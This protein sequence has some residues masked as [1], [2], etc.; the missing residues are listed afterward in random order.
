MDKYPPV[1]GEIVADETYFSGVFKENR[2]RG[3]AGKVL[4]F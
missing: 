4:V 1:S 2:G 3:T